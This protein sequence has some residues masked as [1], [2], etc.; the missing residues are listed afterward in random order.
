ML[1]QGR[2]ATMVDWAFAPVWLSIR[3]A[4]FLSGHDLPAM[5]EIID[6]DG[7]DLDNEEQI[8]KESLWQLL[9][10]ETLI[11]HWDQG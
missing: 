10:A 11:A 3:E 4:C 8:E 6:A 9:E 2:I 1:P 5:L 7:V